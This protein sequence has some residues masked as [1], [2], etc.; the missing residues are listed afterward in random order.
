VRLLLDTHLL[1]WWLA[2][3]P[4]LPARAAQLIADP[5]NDVFVSAISLWEIAIKSRL[6]KLEADVDAILAAVPASGFQP[7]PMS[8]AHAARVAHLPDLH[9]DPF[10]RALVAQAHLE[11]MHLLTHDP[12]VAAYGHGI[13]LV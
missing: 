7:L 9:R 10:D 6:G 1:L 4:A 2:D 3:D 12:V 11:P 8:L 13:E 5:A